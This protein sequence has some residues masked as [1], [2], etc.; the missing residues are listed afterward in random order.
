MHSEP[1]D[2]MWDRVRRIRTW[3]DENTSGQTQTERDLLRVLKIGE[4]FGE[5]AEALHGAHGAN[6]RKGASHTMADVAKELVDVAVTAL[7]ALDTIDPEARKAFDT[8]LQHL[9]DRVV[10]PSDKLA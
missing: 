4:E 10:P 7:I 2:E 1:H 9:V 6:P 3:L 5:A 8:R